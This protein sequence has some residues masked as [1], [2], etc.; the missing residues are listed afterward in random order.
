MRFS[1]HFLKVLPVICVAAAIIAGSV[2]AQ[3]TS[4]G[5][6]DA[7]QQAAAAS[8]LKPQTIC[9]VLGDPI[10]K[11]LYFD[12]KDKRIYVCCASCI[13]SVKADP[14]KYIDKL[15]AQGQSVETIKA[16]KKRAGK[17]TPADTSMK[18]VDM[19]GM[20]MSGDTAKTADAGYWTCTMHPQIHQATSGKCPI[21]GMDLVYK[22]TDKTAPK[23]QGMDNSKT[24]M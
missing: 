24:K 1:K 11:K 5:K 14:Q 10:N 21:C 23:M 17:K 15:K 18:G 6:T 7:P 2:A 16:A 3:I 9:P 20:K 4:D 8:E 19:Q 12:Y 13:D 22:K